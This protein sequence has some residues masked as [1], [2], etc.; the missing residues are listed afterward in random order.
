MPKT[1]GDFW[2]HFEQISGGSNEGSEQWRC[3]HCDQKWVK[4]A[5]RFSKH[6]ES[7][8][9]YLDSLNETAPLP[10]P[11]PTTKRRK[12]GKQTTLNGYTYSFGQKDQEEME[13]LLARAFY[14]AGISF[15]VI[16]NP[17]FCIFLKKA[18]SA[19]KIPSRYKL[20]TTILDAEYNSLKK[21]V[22]NVL[23][24]KEYLCLTSDGWSNI[25][26]TSIVNY[27]ITIPQPFF[28]KSV[29]THEE[30]H[31]AESIA[32]GIKQT[33]EE[34]GEEK[35]VAVITDNAANMKAAWRILKNEYPHKVIIKI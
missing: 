12:A 19:F 29:P 27:M 28:Y 6:L 32:A 21:D 4:N 3:I 5:S 34:I 23:E 14:S 7:C 8:K 17:D 13:R 25:N 31:T 20:S 30:R 22:D 16:D 18:C 2:S 15:N 9:R 11:Q 26:R 1:K 35:I 24:R 10:P 33:I